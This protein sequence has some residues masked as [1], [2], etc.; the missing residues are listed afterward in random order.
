M[1]A[2]GTILSSPASAQTVQDRR[3]HAVA[4]AGPLNTIRAL[5]DA[6]D[7]CWIPP[8]MEQSQPGTEIT[9]RFSLDR[10][11]AIMGEPRFTYSTPT[12]PHDVKAAYQRAIA[13]ALNRCTPFRLSGSLGGAIAG[14]PISTR[15]I[16]DRDRRT[17]GHHE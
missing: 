13:A 12:L 7:A 8:P 5:F 9:I 16:D 14:Q 2:V 11:G 1:L 15:F 3:D 6:L 17:E 4:P 10:A